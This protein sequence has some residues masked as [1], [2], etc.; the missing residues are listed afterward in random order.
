MSNLI[1]KIKNRFQGSS[2]GEVVLAK[3]PMLLLAVAG[4]HQWLNA[5]GW[6]SVIGI[7]VAS[8]F[9][10]VCKNRLS[11]AGQLGVAYL[12]G[13]VMD[14]IIASYVLRDGWQQWWL[15]IGAAYFVGIKL[16]KSAGDKLL[17]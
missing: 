15:A 1:T 17:Q 3:V 4:S 7:I 2:N 11:I 13:W 10:L 8:L 16:A 6:L 9:T 14:D 5:F 12:S